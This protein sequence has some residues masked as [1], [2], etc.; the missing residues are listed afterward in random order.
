MYTHRVRKRKIVFNDLFNRILKLYYL[1]VIYIALQK[2]NRFLKNEISNINLNFYQKIIEILSEM[3]I[4]SIISRIVD[5]GI[6]QCI[7]NNK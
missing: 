6:K 5:S 7:V 3:I 2:T 1:I 4:S